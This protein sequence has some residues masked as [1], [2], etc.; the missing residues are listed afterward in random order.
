MSPLPETGLDGR[1]AFVTGA[2]RGMGATHALTLAS[3]GADVLLAD[4]DVAEL[5]GVA[6]QIREDTG[7][8]VETMQLDVTAPDA[9]KRVRDH[10]E[11]VFGRLDIVVHNAGI[12]HDWRGIADTPAPRLQPYFDAVQD[13]RTQYPSDV[14]DADKSAQLL[15]DAG[16]NASDIHLKYLVDGNHGHLHT[17]NTD[18][19]PA[20]QVLVNHLAEETNLPAT[21]ARRARDSCPNGHF[22][23][24]RR[25]HK[26]KEF[27]DSDPITLPDTILEPVLSR[28]SPLR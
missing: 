11:R 26:A 12:M 23:P 15:K 24:I 13:I 18:S 22:A 28:L 19:R 14:F 8:T 2:A 21:A 20:C 25:L 9:G 1:V 10:A 27:R 17:R 16:V 4:L 5:H 7:R 3:R 6:K